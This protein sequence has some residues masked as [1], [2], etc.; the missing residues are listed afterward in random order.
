MTKK[1]GKSSDSDLIISFVASPEKGDRRS[2]RTDKLLQESLV[3]L[4]QMKNLQEITVSEL[5]ET[6]D[7]SR[8]TFYLHN[9]NIDQLY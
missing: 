6:A 9:D 8:T 7:L 3:E 4:L 1:T 2:K 5:T